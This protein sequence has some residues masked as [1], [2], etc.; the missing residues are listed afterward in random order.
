MTRVKICCI[1]SLA[2]AQLALSAGADMLGLV[3]EMPSGPGPIPDA[4]IA[5]IARAVQVETALLT[6]ATQADDIIAHA[7]R[8]PTTAIQLV[9]RVATRDIRLLREALPKRQIIQVI[10]VNGPSAVDNARDVWDHADALLLDSGSP[11]KAVKELGGTGRVHDW[12][13]SAE[14]V[15]ECPVPVWLAGGLRP[16]NVV[17]A[18]RAVRPFGVDVCSGLR[19]AMVLNRDLLDLFIAAVSRA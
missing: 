11:N 6:A 4:R 9:D 17:E 3:G 15:R 10:H 5:E 8:C 2:E 12:K 14:I 13:I 16:D 18:I 7:T 1:Q 19:R